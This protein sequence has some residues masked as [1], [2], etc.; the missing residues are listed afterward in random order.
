LQ[1]G[2]LLRH[3]CSG[4]VQRRGVHVRL[5]CEGRRIRRQGS[6]TGGLVDSRRRVNRLPLLRRSPYFRAW[7]P[8]L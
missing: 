1:Y 7:R 3:S 5:R 2:R 4:P 6:G 8:E